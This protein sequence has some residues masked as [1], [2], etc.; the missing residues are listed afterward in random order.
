MD[1]T[2]V[3]DMA[4]YY[5]RQYSSEEMQKVGEMDPDTLMAYMNS[6]GMDVSG[7]MGGQTL[8]EIIHQN[9]KEMQRRQSFH[10]SQHF[11]ANRLSMD[12]D[13][14]RTSSMLEFGGLRNNGELDVFQFDP[15]AVHQT[16]NIQR[17]PSH[18]QRPINSQVRQRRD[19]PD[20]LALDTR[21]QSIGHGYNPMN[22]ASPFQTSAYDHSDP[23]SGLD[24][25]SS[26]MDSNMLMGM[27]FPTGGL[28]R[29]NS[30]EMNG[31]K[32]FS[33]NSISPHLSTSSL[34]QDIPHNLR[35]S[36]QDP[37]GGPMDHNLDNLGMSNTTHLQME[38]PI[39]NMP[40]EMRQQQSEIMSP[41]ETAQ[42]LQAQPDFSEQPDLTQQQQQAAS[43][44]LEVSNMA[45]QPIQPGQNMA[46][47]SL[48]SQYK[49]AYSSSGF[50]ML[51]VLMR[52]AARPKPQ[53]NIG[54][55]DM[56]CAF[57]VCDVTQHD[58]PIVYCSDVFERLTGYTK[59]EILGR[60]CRFLQAPDGKIQA[61]V[62]RKYVDDQSIWQIK[63]MI[64]ARQ[65][66]Q[67]SV[68][69]YRKGGQP[70]MNLLTMI[71]ITW[72]S[73]EFKYYVGFQV[74]LVEQPTSITNKNPGKF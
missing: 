67:T 16:H 68:I 9:S 44:T 66:M 47:Q 31:L 69:N 55:V 32:M 11:P 33:P 5:G 17:P 38:H 35:T 37:G 72:D 59:H 21:F 30:G 48:M 73:D 42:Q 14:R 61:G 51:G 24:M 52:V 2:N 28:H 41:A 36:I 8:D 23:M 49:N 1:Q 12:R 25:T 34:Q 18:G 45:D 19:A 46:A 20:D 40:V 7:L 6:H 4:G 58:V 65:E 22:S 62:H 57:V 71:P 74:D 13:P 43:S 29:E 56:S 60:N 27:G 70:F 10:P 53:I 26:Y 64:T 3:G 50:D 54:A 15:S 63:T 39:S